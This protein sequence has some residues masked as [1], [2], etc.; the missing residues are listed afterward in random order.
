MIIDEVLIKLGIDED[1]ESFNSAMD[2]FKK[3]NEF[4][5]GIMKNLASAVVES[6]QKQIAA[7]NDLSHSAASIGMSADEL[8]RYNSAAELAGL[9]SGKLSGILSSLNRQAGEA[10]RG[11]GSGAEAFSMVGISARNAAGEIKSAG[12]LLEDV[13]GKIQGKSR[14]Q[15]Q[16]ILEYLGLSIDDIEYFS[17]NV[18]EAEKEY[19]AIMGAFGTDLN[20]AAAGARSFQNSISRFQFIGDQ[21]ARK[22]TA[23]ILPD[24]S[25]GIDKIYRQV[26]DS[27][28]K[29]AE[30]FAPVKDTISF[31]IKTGTQL[32]SRV[33]E[34]GGRLFSTLKSVNESL[35]GI[36]AKVALVYAGFRALSILLTSS[37]FGAVL[38]GIALLVAAIAD[39]IQTW[40]EGGDSL[41]DWGDALKVA[42][43]T[44]DEVGK[45]V[46]EIHDW[47]VQNSELARTASEYF[48]G[49]NFGEGVRKL[50]DDFKYL[51]RNIGDIFKAVFSDL[52]REFP[53][54]GKAFDLFSSP[55][56]AAPL[57]SSV[58]NIKNS[59][60][61]NNMNSSGGRTMNQT[62]NINI[63][64]SVQAEQVD[65]IDRA[66]KRTMERTMYEFNR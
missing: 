13:R 8:D 43:E 59:S 28:P 23:D 63:S 7:L 52:K 14:V 19:S 54:I 20:K 15:Q 30:E 56:A 44:L 22:L 51:A 58:S 65:D 45:K 5:D 27:L 48:K 49:L 3:L 41:I 17:E 1:N 12:Q 29:M 6:T 4:I 55:S 33:I 62:T 25:D 21:F 34:W 40:K 16:T 57:P 39:D 47:L 36:P 53:F 2:A 11:W 64:G 31:L 61:T 66:V 26:M 10:A 50:V 60:V 32:L 35:G 38:T 46:Q 24:L 37:P 42:S 9:E 18:T